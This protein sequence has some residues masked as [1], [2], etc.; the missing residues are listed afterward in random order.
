MGTTRHYRHAVRFGQHL[1]CA[2]LHSKDDHPGNHSGQI[3]LTPYLLYRPLC[4]QGLMQHSEF[5]QHI[6][7]Q[8]TNVESVKAIV[9]G[10]Y[11]SEDPPLD[12]SH[13]RMIASK[14]ND[15][16][17]PIVTDLRAWGRWVNGGAWLTVQG[18]RVDFLLTFEC[19]LNITT[20]AT[21]AQHYQKNR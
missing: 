4:I 14:L 9:L 8:L 5:V 2:T 1:V 16:P 6:V 20:L 3:A 13:I 21:L 12:I 7:D 10:L 15:F 17:N 11:Y 19:L 18:Q